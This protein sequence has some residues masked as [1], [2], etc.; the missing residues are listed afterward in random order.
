MN[1]T[2]V[3]FLTGVFIGSLGV[4]YSYHAKHNDIRY[5]DDAPAVVWN[6][7][8]ESIPMVGEQIEVELISRDTIYI[9]PLGK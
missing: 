7:D 4:A 3:N 6:D 2:I 9:G 1:K 8:W 5:Y